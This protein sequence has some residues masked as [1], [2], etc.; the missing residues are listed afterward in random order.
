M[1]THIHRTIHTIGKKVITTNISSNTGDR[2]IR[3]NPPAH[4][5]VV[6]AAVE[7]IQ[8]GFGIVVLP[9]VAERVGFTHSFGQ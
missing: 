9:A 4:F 3:I 6:V 1:V 7:V 2:I 5:R 8:L